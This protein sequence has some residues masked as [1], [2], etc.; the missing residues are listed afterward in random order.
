[1]EKKSI[2]TIVA[3]SVLGTAMIIVC[4]FLLTHNQAL[5]KEN[6]ELR[7][8]NHYNNVLAP[9]PLPDS[10]DFAGEQVPLD[11]YLVR[12]ALDRELTSICFQHGTTLL[13]MKRSGRWFPVIEQILKEEGMPED[14][15]YLCVTE[16]SLSNAVSPAKA[17][18]FWQFLSAT[19]KSYGLEVTD[20]V[21][22]RYH[23]EKATHAACK[24]LR[25]GKQSLG[26]W[27][28]AAAGYNMGNAGAK[29]SVTNQSAKGYWDTY[30]NPETARYVYR[31]VAYKLLFENP[32][33][34]GVMIMPNE[35]YQP[36][37]YKEIKVDKTIP[38]LYQFCKEQGVS[39]KLLKECN[40]WLRSTKLTV[41][42]GKSYT[43]K[44]PKK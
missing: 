5:A 18:G 35:K 21:D 43:I 19:A 13:C 33:R 12:E 36:I 24:Y 41:A 8:Q 23:V 7:C 34:Y 37:D 17:A 39:Y 44:L 10:V 29:K 4:V 26:S 42:E 32:Q 30:F 31:I 11:D 1:M 25:S 40:P 2:I 38:S 14:L 16:S 9:P 27:T 6:A 28:L 20:E 15:K 22:E 3:L